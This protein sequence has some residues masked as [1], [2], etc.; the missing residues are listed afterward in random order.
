MLKTK[1]KWL[2]LVLLPIFLEI[3]VFNF[4]SL[5]SRLPGKG[6]EADYG[7]RY[8][9][10]LLPQ[11]DGGY[12]CTNEERCYAELDGIGGEVHTMYLDASTSAHGYLTVDIYG[13]D[14]GNSE[15]YLMGSRNLVQGVEE[16]KWMDLHFYGKA[17][18][19]R[20]LFHTG[21][22]KELYVRKIRLN[23]PK[24]FFI[25][26]ARVALLY[27]AGLFLWFLSREATSIWAV[28]FADGCRNRKYSLASLLVFAS[29][30]LCILAMLALDAPTDSKHQELTEAFT[31]GRLSIDEEPPQYLLTMDNPYD[32]Q[33]REAL[34]AETEEDYLWDYAFYDGKYY[35]YFGVVPVL[36]LYLPVYLLTGI[37]L[38][39]KTAMGLFGL[40]LAAA[41]FYLVR[42]IFRR[43]FED[44]PYVL[45]P[46]LS[47]GLTFGTGLVTLMRKPGVYEVCIGSGLA[48]VLLGTALWISAGIGERMDKGRLAL[49]SLCVA[50]TAGCRPQFLIAVLIGVALFLPYFIQR[51]DFWPNLKGR[52]PELAA[53]C[54]PFVAIGACTMLYNLARFDSIFE[55]GATYNL[56]TNDVTRRGSNLDRIG[57]GIYEYV[58]RPMGIQTQFPFIH[59]LEMDTSYLG[60][61]V[62]EH[63]F[64][65]IL[66]FNPLLFLI[67]GKGAYGERKGEASIQ[68]SLTVCSLIGVFLVLAANINM[69]GILERYQSDFVW[70][71]YVAILLR[72]LAKERR[73]R[74]TDREAVL[75][76]Q[77]AVLTLLTVFLNF[78]MLWQD[79]IY[80][81]YDNNLIL[82]TRLKYLF[83]FW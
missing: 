41:A 63:R 79:D 81:V 6:G 42:E 44:C 61:T 7:L 28:S 48:F 21:Y 23:L 39:S 34:K 57:Y 26:W 73:L 78:L 60:L 31:Q 27:V 30:C 56:T 11:E 69:G 71:L 72:I 3:L 51:R 55:F 82:F 46:I 70:L 50:L 40:L 64:G 33:A 83:E 9:Q 49:G 37:L 12:L 58:F 4:S 32:F 18:R 52:L 45:Y 22:N 35:V 14:E 13:A 62:F 20:L 36:L 43:W 75:H 68:K 53:F 16:S 74:G 24:P 76:R 65:G 59:F 15:Y 1:M 66:W 38:S 19:I 10:S 8:S 17:E 54:I 47:V 5:R 29:V 67:F 2:L 80:D 25:D 77:I